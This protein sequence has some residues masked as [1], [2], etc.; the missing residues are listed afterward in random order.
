M[1]RQFLAAGSWVSPVEE[2]HLSLLYRF[3]YMNKLRA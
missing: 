1:K 2:R 3:E